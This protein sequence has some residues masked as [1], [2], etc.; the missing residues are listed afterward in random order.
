MESRRALVPLMAL[1]G[2]SLLAAMWAG[3]IRLGWKFPEPTS[4]FL[5]SHGPLMIV[6]FLGTV[7]GL[8]RAVAV[9]KRWAY[10]APIFGALSG[11]SQLVGLPAEL[12]QI[13]GLVAAL[14]LVAIFTFLWFRRHES[15]LFIIGFGALLWLIGILLWIA[16][17]PFPDVASWWAGFLVLTIG[18]ERLELSR[19]MRLSVWS[20]AGLFVAIAVFFLGLSMSL[21]MPA[22]GVALAGAGLI[23]VAL[24]LLRY[25]LAWRTIRQSGLSRFTAVCLLSGYFWLGIAGILWISFAGHFT[26]GFRYDAMLHAIILGF[27]FSMSFGHSPIIFP[28]ILGISMPFQRAFYAHLV[29]LHLSL[30]LRIGGDLALWRPGQKWGALLNA[31]A[32]VVFLANNI[33]A[34]RIGH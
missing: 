6:G 5:S 24:W 16:G 31:A 21:F 14:S 32:I 27:V 8:E 18:G 3:L 34:V 15:Y 26:A 2:L 25:D 20:R 11:L 33:R 4:G 29:L 30:F 13:F 10:L 9:E 1:G 17:R 12:G 22:A 23:A 7:I 19:L 28:S